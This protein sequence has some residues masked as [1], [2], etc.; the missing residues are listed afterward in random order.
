MSRYVRGANQDKA[1]V[2]ILFPV[3]TYH[4]FRRN[5]TTQRAAYILKDKPADANPKPD[6]ENV[7]T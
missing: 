3:V 7:S 2:D 4:G 1:R 6:D 5:Y